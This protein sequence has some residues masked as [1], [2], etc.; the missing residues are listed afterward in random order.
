MVMKWDKDMI[1]SACKINLWWHFARTISF[2]LLNY[3]FKF[4]KQYWCVVVVKILLIATM[5]RKAAI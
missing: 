3:I 2:L 5:A 4:C 1:M